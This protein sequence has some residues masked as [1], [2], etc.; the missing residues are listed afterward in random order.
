M[1]C[2]DVETLSSFADTHY[3]KVRQTVR[4]SAMEGTKV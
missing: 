2:N 4:D 1:H 3:W